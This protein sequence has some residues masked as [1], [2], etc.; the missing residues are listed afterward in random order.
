MNI[1]FIS[2][3]IFLFGSI[4]GSFLNVCIHRLPINESIVSPR[5]HC[6]KCKNLITWYDNIPLFSY[7]YLK[8]K[9]R[10]CE[11][12]IP[13]RY[14]LVEL[15]N[16]ILYLS[17]FHL[18]FPYNILLVLS[19]FIFTSL[20]IVATFV[21][22]KYF[23]IPD[24][25]SIGGTVAG[26]LLSLICPQLMQQTAIWPSF[27]RS[28]F[29]GLICSGLLLFIAIS[30]TFF[31]KKEAMGM[32]D[33]KLLAMIGTF[34]GWKLGLFSILLASFIGSFVGIAL[35]LGKGFKWQS[36]IPFGPYLS[37]GA[38][39]SLFFGEKMINFYLDLLMHP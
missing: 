12:N 18:F 22:F 23:I 32:G 16:G 36:Q 2:I 17:I 38:L 24:S 27:L 33:V 31:L 11:N 14:F 21:D 30:A 25:I 1:L 3:I 29:S 20:L 7:L 37:L 4:V 34:I 15:L 39:I 9:C 10:H 8:G 26:L 5:S 13:F 6:P 28:F 19:Y 35:I